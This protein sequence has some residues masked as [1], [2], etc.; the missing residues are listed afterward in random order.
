MK[1][2]ALVV[3]L[4]ILG[5]LLSIVHAHAEN[6]TPV[7]KSVMIE[8]NR[9]IDSASIGA[10]LA[11]KTG[12]ALSMDSVRDDIRALYGIGYFDNIKVDIE[13]YD[14]GVRLHYAVTEKPSIM[15]VEFAG[16]KEVS[17]EKLQEQISVSAGAMADGKLIDDNTSRIVAHYE[18][19]GFWDIEV[20]PILNLISKD[21][22]VLTYNIKEG[23]KI[24]VREITIEG[25][26]G[27]ETGAIRNVM[28][29]ETAGIFSYF[30]SSGRYVGS[31]M[32]DDLERIKDLYHNNGYISVQ[33]HRSEPDVSE[34]R[35]SMA[36]TIKINEGAQ[37]SIGKVSVSGAV[38]MPSS[39]IEA[40]LKTKS[41]QLFKRDVLRSDVIA[42]T[43]YYADKGYA[44]TDVVPDIS[45]REKEKL[46][47]LVMLIDEK[48][49]VRVGR[50]NI[51]GN[52]STRDKVIRREL[53]LDEGDTYIPKLLR[54]SYQRINN[55]NFFE[56]VELVPNPKPT[57]GLMDLTIKVK[58]RATGS[59]NMGGGYSSVDGLMATVDVTEGNLFG[60]GQ[61]LKVSSEVSHKGNSYS[62]SFTEPWLM[63]K[64]LSLT[65]KVYDTRHE[66][67][68]YNRHAKGL[69]L[70]MGK[71]LSEYVRGSVGYSFERA[72]ISNI[73][74]S[75][76]N[77]IK[78][79]DGT[80][81]TSEISASLSRDT[82]DNYLNPREGSKYSIYTTLAG[83]GGDNYFTRTVIDSSWH[84]P[85]FTE[86]ALSFGTRIGFAKGIES[87]EL[88][89]YE[90][91]YVGGMN[92]V[93]GHKY[94]AAGPLDKDGGKLGGNKELVFNVEYIFPLA[95]E[96]RLYGVLFFD[97]GS[98]LREDQDFIGP[99]LR[100]GVGAGFR[101]ISP[102]GPLRL[103]WARN[104]DPRA[105]EDVYMWEFTFGT[106]F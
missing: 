75:A 83:L 73:S 37:Y 43:D 51:L 19:E 67:L 91:F 86:S 56:A 54:R 25:N 12:D 22:A 46:V 35:K 100:E 79:Q 18:K 3:A 26:S 36:I 62:V 20:F 48:S 104:V 66:D 50:V 60:R 30:T 45:L 40:L 44:F 76:S 87:R 69:G 6:I 96:S 10:R 34:D 39:E 94:G 58:E 29:T 74:D 77:E 27:I 5:L 68:Y 33:V 38:K 55:L 23:D 14:G 63:D 41:G 32:R 98:A 97:S 17:T 65:T 106:F 99:D 1:K 16:N 9:K 15:K 81:D 80:K 24:K 89:L 71:Q 102:I 85:L 70:T 7:V 90:R 59:L 49:L 88:P 2:Q 78:A 95:A 84:W 31:V 4:I 53:R 82:R 105:G 52:V 28:Q 11:T 103:E 47:D 57:E 8:G 21:A 61:T 92:S 42:V 72:T 13:E 93:R 101:W 64:P